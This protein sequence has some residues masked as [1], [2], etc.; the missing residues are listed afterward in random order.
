ME[1]PGCERQKFRWFEA[2]TNLE[3]VRVFFVRFHAKAVVELVDVIIFGIHFLLVE[4]K[5]GSR[6]YNRS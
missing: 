4:D 5:A 6:L 1:S 2:V 3:N